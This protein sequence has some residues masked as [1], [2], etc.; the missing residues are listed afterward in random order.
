[1]VQATICVI[2]V[3]V[4]TSVAFEDER[5]RF[6]KEFEPLDTEATPTP[7]ADEPTYRLPND[8]RPIRY[9]IELKTWIDQGEFDFT[10]NVKIHLRVEEAH[11]NTI[12]IHSY[13]Q[14]ILRTELRRLD[15]R[16]VPTFPYQYDSMFQFLTVQIRSGFLLQHEEFILEIDYTSVLR[17]DDAG[18]YRSSYVDENGVRRWLATTQFEATDARH[19]FPCYDEPGIRSIYGLTIVHGSSYAAVANMPVKHRTDG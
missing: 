10:G 5:P 1:M 6:Y 14:T 11:T 12:T 7:R 8:T 2:F 4:A 15:G 18:F 13:R 19:A 3:L 16:V 17:T 9:D